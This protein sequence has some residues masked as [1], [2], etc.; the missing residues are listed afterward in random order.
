MPA[1]EVI[2][3]LQNQASPALQQTATD[4]Q[5][6]AAALSR[7]A[8]AA[9]DLTGALRQM[10]AAL[11]ATTSAQASGTAQTL[12]K[13]RAEATAAAAIGDHRTAIELLQ[14]EL[15]RQAERT[16]QVIAAEG[17]LNALSIREADTAIRVAQSQARA[18]V[19]TKD[20]AGALQILNAAKAQNADGSA[21]AVASLETQIAQTE[22]AGT[23]TG[24]LSAQLGALVSPLALVTAG[25]GLAVG[26]INSLGDALDFAGK[27]QEERRAFGGILG[28]FQKGNATLDEATQRGRL[29][30]FTQKEVADAFRELAPIIRTST[31]TTQDQAEALARISVLKP[32]DP[33]RALSG[34]IEGLQTGKIKELARELGLSKPEQDALTRS[35]LGGTDAFVAL[36]AALDRHGIT[37]AVARERTEGLVG[38]Q[39]RQ[40]QVEEDLQ[41]AEAGFAAGPGL[42]LLEQRIKVTNDATQAFGGSLIGL[43]NVVGDSVGTFNPILGAITSYNNAVLGAGDSALRWAGILPQA[44]A[45][46]QA[47]T[48]AVAANA[49]ATAQDTPITIAQTAAFDD[50]RRA[51]GQ[52]QVILGASEGD[53]QKNANASALDAAKKDLQAAATKKT[54]D[55]TSHAADAFLALNPTMDATQAYA[56]AIAAGLGEVV[57]KIV[58]LRVETNK[59]KQTLGDQLLAAQQANT[60]V[61]AGNIG[62]NAPAF[63]GS[64]NNSVDAVVALQEANKKAADDAKKDNAS[65][66][67]SEIALARAKKDTA[68]EIDLLRQKQSQLDRTTVA[69]Q[70]QFNDI[71]AQI[72]SIQQSSGRTRV[73]A[74]QSTALQLQNVEEN[75]GLQLA[76]IQRENLERLRDQQEDYDV[77]RARSQEDEDRKIQGLLARG[78]KLQADRERADFARQQQRDREDFD[79][80]RRRTLRNNAEA[81]GDLDNRTD[82]RTQQIGNR[83]ALRGVN[84]GALPSVPGASA[85]AASLPSAAAGTRSVTQPM[86]LTIYFDSKKVGEQLW[87]AYLEEKVDGELALSIMQGGVPNSGQVGVG[88]VG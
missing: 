15:A 13:A 5:A 39:R 3:Q 82:L 46:T 23:A 20:Y 43:N 17:Q 84:T 50:E 63:A 26:A 74:A 8:L 28:D 35:V 85:G 56:L 41:I 30:G 86:P 47:Q 11:G 88:G 21:L 68:R 62:S 70:A 66:L 49:Q 61:L 32:D 48:A 1:A 54:A 51:L 60:Q 9:G 19:A 73:S 7:E 18:A 33:V 57:A 40:K 72:I 4:A 2:L 52:L 67:D 55:E 81:V 10:D 16:N 59:T 31:S 78:Q 14:A 25:A 22:A 75:S 79:R 71:Q 12:S 76:R 65:L 58:A 37:L 6:V 27:L 44:T 77:K 69:G 34:A 42:A 36:N 53:I 83:A 64:Q 29:Y 38:A 87:L 24:A 80:E 45:A